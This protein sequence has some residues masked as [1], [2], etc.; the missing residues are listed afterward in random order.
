[1]VEPG[2][3]PPRSD[4]RQNKKRHLEFLPSPTTQRK[5]QSIIVSV[6]YGGLPQ[7]HTQELV[8]HSRDGRTGWA[9]AQYAGP[10]YETPPSF[11]ACNDVER[12]LIGLDTPIA[13]GR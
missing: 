4:Y 8:D 13:K 6:S 1:V 2:I 9:M 12:T 5:S 3:H 11:L 7:V 10:S